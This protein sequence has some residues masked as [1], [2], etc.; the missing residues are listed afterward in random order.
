MDLALR[1]ATLAALNAF[2]TR[3]NALISAR[4]A[5]IVLAIGLAALVGIALLDRAWLLPD[6]IRPWVSVAAYI[7]LGYA[8]WQLALRTLTSA[9]DHTLTARL[10]EQSAPEL[11]EKLL[12]AVELARTAPSQIKDSH[13]FRARL[14]DQVAAIA[15]TLDITKALPTT[16]LTPWAR[17]LGLALLGTVLLSLIP[18]L[19]LPGFLARAALPFANLERPSS[20]KI[21]I[22]TPATSPSIAP[23]ASEVSVSARITSQPGSSL[24]AATIEY[25]EP[26]ASPRRMDLTRTS[27]TSDTFDTRLP[28]GQTDIR[29]RIH[30]ADAISP[31][32]TIAAKPRPRILTFVKTIAPPAYV[33][34][35]QPITITEDHGDLEALAG[36]TVTLAL[37]PNQPIEKA[38]IVFDP[39]LATHAPAPA[40]AITPAALNAQLNLDGKSEAWTLR[41]TAAD[42]HFTND[43]AASWHITT[44]P[45]LPPLASITEPTEQQEALADETL[46]ILGLASD[47]VGLAKLQLSQ[48][49][50]GEKPTTLDLPLIASTENGAPKTEN[51]PIKEAT[52]QHLLILPTLQL[53]PSDTLQ[54]RFIATDLKGQRTESPPL[55]IIILEQ[56]ID[57][58]KRAFAL[59]QKALAQKATALAETTRQLTKDAS[60]A[61]KTARLEQRG[62]PIT[63][64]EVKLSRLKQ[65][66]DTTRAQADDLWQQLKAA[67]AAAPDAL[68]AEETQLLGQKLAQLRRDPLAQAEA[69]THDGLESTEALKR[70]AAEASS[71][72]ARIEDAARNFATAATAN[73]ALQSAQQSTRQQTTLTATA[74]DANRD[75]KQRPKWQEQQRAAIDARQDMAADIAALN[76]IVHGGHQHNI[77]EATKSLTETTTDLAAALDR[78]PDQPPAPPPAPAPQSATPQGEKKTPEALYTAADNLRNRLTRT[79]DTVK[80]IAEDA[81]RRAAE[82]RRNLQQQDNPALQALEKAKAH[83]HDAANIA[84]DPKRQAKQKADKEGNTAPDRAQ[85][86]L[87]QASQQLQDQGELKE[88]NPLTNTQAALDTNR[89]SRAA[90]A[91]RQATQVAAATPNDTPAK[92]PDKSKN[93]PPT[94]PNAQAQALEAARAQATELSAIARALDADQLAQT[95][96]AALAK[97]QTPGATPQAKS[98]PE[99]T[100]NIATAAQAA[101]E[102]LAQLPQAIRRTEAPT[103]EARQAQN[104]TAQLAQQAADQAR[105]AANELANQDRQ[106]QQQLADLKPGQPSPTAPPTPGNLTEADAKTR[107]LALALAQQAQT[108]RDQ[109]LALTPKVSDMMKAVAQD[110]HQNADKTQDA[111]KQAE[112][113]QPVAQVAKEAQALQTPA[114]AN[115]QKM[116]ALAAALRQEA[117]AAELDQADQRQLA[118]TADV[119]L[120]SMRQKT[121]QIAANLQ[122]ATR[123]QASQ[124]QATALQKAAQALQKAAQGLDQLAQSFQ[125]MEAGQEIP[126]AQLAAL[127]EME[128]QL[129]IEA[130]LDEAYDKAADLAKAQT[131]AQADPAKALA[132]LEAQLKA[133]PAM[134][135]ALANLAKE[136]A[137]TAQAQLASK[138]NQPAFLGTAAEDAA[139][140]ISRVARHQTRLEKP[141]AAKANAAAAAALQQTA[142]TTKT[143][144]GNATP[145]VA[146]AAQQAAATAA[147]AAQQSAAEAPSAPAASTPLAQAQATQLA[148]ALDQLDQALHPAN[149]Q[150]GQPQPPQPGQPQQGA[151]QQSLAQAQQNQSQQMAQARAEG[152]VPGQGS[153]QATAQNNQKGKPGPPTSGQGKDGTPDGKAQASPDG[154]LVNIP[155]MVLADWGH[156]PTK[157]AED[158]SEATRQ[159]ASPE[160]R[161][162][163]ENYYKAIAAKGKK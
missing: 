106:T 77:Y 40:V 115:A 131:D 120:E 121:P 150:P 108:A 68:A 48:S 49:I 152:K 129:G 83:L 8:A 70:A 134:Q 30:A 46:R 28:I 109:L 47:D 138:A 159:E 163:I 4:A 93:N 114:A 97:A 103:N 43:E 141:A 31:W 11:R 66:L 149:A 100:A 42:T 2:R 87:A 75:A 50:N 9:S 45:D 80:N 20:V 146:A 14:Q 37:T 158:L 3:R 155:V 124:P 82:T 57:P 132:D 154:V 6:L 32:H 140:E 39:D 112:A 107:Q 13:E 147:E 157:M 22:L 44:I 17:H 56:T 59:A 72:A 16:T 90:E 69:L 81:T 29:F 104:Q 52:T 133:S 53:K 63:D 1:P 137:Q 12:A 162:A 118:R 58:A 96:V 102:A 76:E 99:K 21:A 88:Q 125:K 24:S 5:L 128:A 127:G 116:D 78:T 27:S 110:L 148:T 151:A 15:H 105:N 119:A 33:P 135:K 95:A 92:A 79:R 139:H 73:I 86:E 41:L 60:Q 19:H 18:T 101:S 25:G 84:A 51:A 35:A 144:P 126:E 156:L 61:Q 26:T 122:E 65:Q 23:I 85:A 94:P 113:A 145:A 136:T 111:Q 160:Y 54:L 161:A 89:T 38:E 74:L 62:K 117:N 142:K 153:Q 123:A 36:S 130:P 67:A 64:A 71:L 10:A 143:E 34:T 7:A 91:L 55:R 98:L